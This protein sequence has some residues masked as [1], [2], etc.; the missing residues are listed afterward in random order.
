M[1]IGEQGDA[2]GDAGL[3]EFLGDK[4]RLAVG[5]RVGGELGLLL[6][7][8]F[9]LV[10][11]MEFTSVFLTRRPAKDNSK[12]H[13]SESSNND[14]NNDDGDDAKEK[15]VVMGDF[16]VNRSWFVQMLGTT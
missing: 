6:V 13:D 16:C 15:V 10:M 5:P 11:M 8:S 3:G 1:M 7:S 9:F 2:L 12:R 14:T 4:D